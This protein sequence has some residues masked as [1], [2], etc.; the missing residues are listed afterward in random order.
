MSR[1]DFSDLE[2]DG[3]AECRQI[4][5]P[6]SSASQGPQALPGDKQARLTTRSPSRKPCRPPSL[7]WSL[8]LP[9]GTVCWAQLRSRGRAHPTPTPTPVGLLWLPSQWEEGRPQNQPWERAW[10][11][12]PWGT[13]F[14]VLETRDLN[15]LCSQVFL[16]SSVI[17]PGI[18]LGL[19]EW[20]GDHPEFILDYCWV[21]TGSSALSS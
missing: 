6:E 14:P 10:H 15:A 5:S 1:E 20:E 7:L 9:E 18:A 4:K 19:I 16:P 13:K 11:A 3:L 2:A 21:P 17:R 8:R 12:R